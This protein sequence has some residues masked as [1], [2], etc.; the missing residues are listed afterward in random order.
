MKNV[1]FNLFMFNLLVFQNEPRNEIRGRCRVCENLNFQNEAKYSRGDRGSIFFEVT[2]KIKST[3]RGA[4][5]NFTL[6]SEAKTPRGEG[7]F[8]KN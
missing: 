8:V 7:V 4:C 6:Q 2:Q 5:E 3:E 1:W